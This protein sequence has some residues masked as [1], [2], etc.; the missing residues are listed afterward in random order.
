[1]EA[2]ASPR[3]DA[4]AGEARITLYINGLSSWRRPGPQDE[5]VLRPI[6]GSMNEPPYPAATSSF[7][8][9]FAST[10]LLTGAENR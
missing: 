10:E 7:A 5:K 8:S 3:S 9:I 2:G 4:M 1:M 6:S